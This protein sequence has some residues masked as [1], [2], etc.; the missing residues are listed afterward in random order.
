M[1]SR[2]RSRSRSATVRAG[3]S[4]R[5]IPAGTTVAEA[6]AILSPV[7][8]NLVLIRGNRVLGDSEKLR[9]SVVY[10]AQPELEGA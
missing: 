5:T 7:G 10:V 8:R 2:S 1:A 6:K 9:A 4:R 3:N